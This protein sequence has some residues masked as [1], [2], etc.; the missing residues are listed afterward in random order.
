MASSRST[1]KE[2]ER[3]WN[4]FRVG[5]FAVVALVAAV[6]GY[7]FLRGTPILGGTYV[8]E[9]TFERAEGV[10][11]DAPVTVRG[12]RVGR[13]ERVALSNEDGVLVRMR[14]QNDVQLREGTTASVTGMSAL[15]DVSISLD[16]S[17][18]GPPLET[19]AR[20]PTRD[21]GTLDKL[22]QKALPLA[23]RVDTVLA[24][25]GGT[26]AEAERL[27]GGSRGDVQKTLENLRSTSSGIE[28]LLQ[29]ERDRLH[30]T[31]V[32]LERT[33]AS[34]DTLVH[35]LQ[36]VTSDNRDT[37]GV[38]VQEAA[39]TLQRTRRASKSVAQSADD[40]Q[41]ILGGLRKGEGTAGQLLTD[42]RL[43]Q[44]LHSISVRTDSILADFQKNPGRYLDTTVEIF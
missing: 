23:R 31:L 6:I 26:F 34:M 33:S 15:D 36:S 39:K 30:R 42:P 5:V 2:H 40:L 20:I 25:A 17:S 22:R 16:R 14:I 27:L 32:H 18:S 41:H 12:I 7:Q 9:A 8:L 28:S 37:L 21:Q 3:F 44:R 1:E 13:V 38:A 35:D 4:E 29:R 10:T 19:G 24:N 43:Y 11:A